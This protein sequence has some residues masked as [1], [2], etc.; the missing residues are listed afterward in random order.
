MVSCYFDK[1]DGI[2]LSAYNGTSQFGDFTS[3][4]TY[5]AVVKLSSWPPE[6]SFFLLTIYL[7]IYIALILLFIPENLDKNASDLEKDN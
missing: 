6:S 4:I 2:A 5:F 3:L 7:I 1:S